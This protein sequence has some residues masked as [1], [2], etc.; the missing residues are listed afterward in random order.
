[1]SGLALHI[2]YNLLTLVFSINLIIKE[3]DVL[4]LGNKLKTNDFKVFS[5][6]MLQFTKVLLPARVIVTI[7]VFVEAKDHRLRTGEHHLETEC[8]PLTGR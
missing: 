6:D 5:N 3:K 4:G 2:N 8:H 7:S 1:L